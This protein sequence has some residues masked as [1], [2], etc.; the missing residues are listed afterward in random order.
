MAQLV[1]E[2]VS[3]THP[4][5]ARLVEA[6]QEVYVGIYGGRDE[7]PLED[8]YFDPPLG[9]FFVGYLEGRPVATGAWRFRPDVAGELG[10]LRPA[11]I[12][13]MYVVPTEQ[14]RGLGRQMLA[15]LEATA[16]EHGATDLIL[17]TG[18]PQTSAIGL[19]E[20]AGY[21]PVPSF[22]HYR[23]EPDNRCFAR[24]LTQN[25]DKS[26]AAHLG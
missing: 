7:T 1:I 19:Y 13:R 22:G 23:D 18:A 2:R 3:I 24:S 4:D 15:H 11:E 25:S 6:V 5:A 8:G 20:S 10:L 17:E 21:S 12:K 14:R 16:Q 9:A 26:D